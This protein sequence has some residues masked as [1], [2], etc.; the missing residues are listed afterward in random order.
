MK[1][2]A[3]VLFVLA[4][5]C[6]AG[7]QDKAADAATKAFEAWNSHDAEKVASMYAADIVY[8]DV[9]F[10]ESAKGTAEMKKF[11]TG[12]FTS[13]PD[14][15]IEVTTSFVANGHGYLEWVFSGTDKGF[16]NTGKRFSIHGAS[17]FEMRDGKIVH[18]RDYYDTGS[19][20]KQVG[21]LK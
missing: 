15:K 8:E 13:V 18:N 6:L 4:A 11:A 3:V 12:L 2:S 21:A 7:A 10:G 5:V 14:V 19:I 16:Y 1:R 17:V 9:P 20:M